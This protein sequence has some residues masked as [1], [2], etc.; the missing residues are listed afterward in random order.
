MMYKM[1]EGRAIELRS[2]ITTTS[3]PIYYS[4]DGLS[5]YRVATPGEVLVFRAR[6]F[7]RP[8]TLV[9]ETTLEIAESIRYLRTLGYT[10][11][12]TGGLQ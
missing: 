8:F 7:G 5:V 11:N 3:E 12:S 1:L 10:V 9:A 4:E 6:L 2:S